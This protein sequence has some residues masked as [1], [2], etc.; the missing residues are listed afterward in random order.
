MGKC[1]TKKSLDS[2]FIFE[3]RIARDV[4]EAGAMPDLV[5]IS[6]KKV[7]PIYKGG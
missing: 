5:D 7:Q 6:G 3:R 2:D 4:V 1:R